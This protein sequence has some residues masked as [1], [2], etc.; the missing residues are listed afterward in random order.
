[1][2]AA[3]DEPRLAVT[4]ADPVLDFSNPEDP[5]IAAAEVS[6][7]SVNDDAAVESDNNV[8]GNAAD[9]RT[10]QTNLGTSDTTRDIAVGDDIATVEDGN[11][12][13][14]RKKYERSKRNRNVRRVLSTVKNKI[15]TIQESY[16]GQPNFPPST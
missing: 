5:N 13:K 8:R 6:L 9:P 2:R 12:K 4:G 10:S 3:E 7:N 15:E 14:K 1:M 11:A 16:G